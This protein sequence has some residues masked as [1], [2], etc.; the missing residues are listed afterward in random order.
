M[1]EYEL[2]FR[3]GALRAAAT[4]YATALEFAEAAEAMGKGAPQADAIVKSQCE[5]LERAAIEFALAF[6]HVQGVKEEE[7]KPEA[8]TAPKTRKP[9]QKKDKPSSAD[10]AALMLPGVNG[11]ATN[12]AEPIEVERGE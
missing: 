12:D 8:A 9:R 6:G 4:M 7:P 1:S 10:D 11:H 3:R 2:K 5:A